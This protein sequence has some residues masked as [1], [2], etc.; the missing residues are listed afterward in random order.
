MLDKIISSTSSIISLATMT[1]AGLGDAGAWHH[2]TVEML[3]SHMGI[4]FVVFIDGILQ[5][6]WI[7]TSGSSEEG[8]LLPSIAWEP[9]DTSDLCISCS[10]RSGADQGPAGSFT[11]E[12]RDLL[13]FSAALKTHALSLH[14]FPWQAWL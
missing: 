12:L 11:G 5:K 7:L 8:V 6:T 3:H 1:L 9:R 4:C 14:S 13:L 2:A 10:L